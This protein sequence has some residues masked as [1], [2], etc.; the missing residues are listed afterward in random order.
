MPNTVV[1]IPGTPPVSYKQVN[2]DTFYEQQYNDVYLRWQTRLINE[3]GK[4]ASWVSWSETV[5]GVEISGEYK[6]TAIGV[7]LLRT[8]LRKILEA[9]EGLPQFVFPNNKLEVHAYDFMSGSMGLMIRHPTTG[10]RKAVLYLGE[11]I[12][13]GRVGAQLVAHVVSGNTPNSSGIQNPKKA[14]LF[15][16]TGILHEFGHLFHSL[17]EPDFYSFVV[18]V[19]A[20][21]AANQLPAPNPFNTPLNTVVALRDHVRALADQGQMGNVISARCKENPQEFV[22]ECFA[23]QVSGLKLTDQVKEAYA[24]LGGPP[25]DGLKVK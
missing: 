25:A 14:D 2:A 19:A 17:N 21:A 10:E 15:V 9:M 6:P 24:Y 7:D 11:S 8:Q 4:N 23:A 22:A 5:G 1:S 3:A 13:G 18:D 16:R 20:T 12:G